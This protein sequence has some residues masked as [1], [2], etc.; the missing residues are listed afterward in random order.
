M[1]AKKDS[2]DV[3][4]A[5]KI[6]CTCIII[7]YF[8]IYIE[9]LIAT[10]CCHSREKTRGKYINIYIYIVFLLLNIIHFHKK[11]VHIYIYLSMI[12]IQL[13]MSQS[14]D[15]YLFYL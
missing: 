12:T 9:R 5:L 14:E 15:I 4:H 6:I 11:L 2:E 1:A 10:D 7:S 3:S 8:L 13:I